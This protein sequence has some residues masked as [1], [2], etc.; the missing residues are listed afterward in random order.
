MVIGFLHE[1]NHIYDDSILKSMQV[2][3]AAFGSQY[4]S[5]DTGELIRFWS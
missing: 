1:E 2:D 5:N 3:V 4:G